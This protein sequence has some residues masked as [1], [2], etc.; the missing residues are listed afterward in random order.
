MGR[1]QTKLLT[2]IHT[3]KRAHMYN[4]L[5]NT[6]TYSYLEPNWRLEVEKICLTACSQLPQETL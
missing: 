6:Y 5:H 3:L 4:Y 1:T 2:L